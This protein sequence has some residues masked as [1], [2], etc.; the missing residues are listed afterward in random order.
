M[1]FRTRALA[2]IAVAAVTLLIV[3]AVSSNAGPIGDDAAAKGPVWTQLTPSTSPSSLPWSASA[4]DPENDQVVVFGGN[5]GRGGSTDTWVF[6]GESWT[7]LDLEVYPDL[8]LQAAMAYDR[9]R[10][11]VVLFGGGCDCAA[12]LYGDTWVFDGAQWTEL[13]PDTSP[14]EVSGS[15]MAYDPREREVV[16]FGGQSEDGLS[17]ETWVWDGRT[18]RIQHPA[19]SPPARR[20]AGMAYS[21]RLGG[22]VLFGG[23]GESLERFGDTW[24]W[25]DGAWTEV[26]DASGGLPRAG[27]AMATIGRRVVM[28]GGNPGY[29]DETWV[30]GRDTWHERAKD[31]SPPGRHAAAM[32]YDSTRRR[33]VLFGGGDGFGEQP[34]DTWVLQHRKLIGPVAAIS[35]RSCPRPSRS[36]APRSGTPYGSAGRTG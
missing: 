11:E 15:R 20:S 27:V 8:R 29:S 26:P 18:W 28:F 13:H 22:I 4:Y 6:D 35:R 23:Q 30:L 25:K 32:A 12:L 17:N 9:A 14:P 3:P 7:L 36:V 16:M 19:V 33:V 24:L 31:L 34:R 10:G 5:D 2:L 1:F 21:P